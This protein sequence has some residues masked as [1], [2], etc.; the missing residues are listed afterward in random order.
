[1]FKFHLNSREYFRAIVSPSTHSSP[2]KGEDGTFDIVAP[3]AI[4]YN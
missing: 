1:L 3:C 4:V 2:I